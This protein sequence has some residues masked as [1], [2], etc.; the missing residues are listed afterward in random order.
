MLQYNTESTC[1][2]HCVLFSSLQKFSQQGF[3]LYFFLSFS[4][5]IHSLP[6]PFTLYCPLVMHNPLDVQHH[7]DEGKG[8][9]YW[10]HSLL[11]EGGG[12]L[13]KHHGSV[14][15]SHRCNSLESGDHRGQ[16]KRLAF[17]LF[18]RKKTFFPITTSQMKACLLKV[19]LPIGQ[20]LLQCL[21]LFCSFLQLFAQI[22]SFLF[23]QFMAN[24]IIFT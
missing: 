24:L 13:M 22:V 12:S 11:A 17:Y 16:T 1:H 18:R 19:I 9:T 7:G 6:H 23:G 20:L 14:L 5:F 21:F 3:A 8:T 4:W 10:L 2:Y 15:W